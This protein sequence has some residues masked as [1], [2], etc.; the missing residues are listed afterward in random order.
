MIKAI[1]DR[2]PIVGIIAFSLASTWNLFYLFTT[3]AAHP[4]LIF[5]APAVMVELVTAGLVYYAVDLVRKTLLSN[6]SIQDRRFYRVML[7]TNLVLVIPS[8][9]LSVWANTS[10][11]GT[12]A[13]GAMFPL[14]AVAC[15]VFLGIPDAMN[16]RRDAQEKEKKDTQRK[17]AESR[18]KA[19]QAAEKEIARARQARERQIHSMGKAAQVYYKLEQE[20]GKTI[21]SIAQDFGV[22]PQAI[23]QHVTKLERAGLVERNGDGIKVVE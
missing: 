18:R 23:S 16:K 2:L 14:M 4:G 5:W 19:E 15:A 12:V 1:M 17:Q 10:E 8:L 3:H 20:P 13:L 22:S 21:S 7:V 11:F 6:I 9:G